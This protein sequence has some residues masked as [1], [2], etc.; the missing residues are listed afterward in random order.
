MGY[1]PLFRSVVIVLICSLAGPAGCARQDAAHEADADAI[2]VGAG[3]AGLSAAVEMGRAGLDVLVV[4]M[5][6]VP[7]GTAVRAGGIAM[8]GT[9]ARRPAAVVP[10]PP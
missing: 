6:S 10:A 1:Q 2:V 3:L 7:G 5:N 4:D 8:V 9:P